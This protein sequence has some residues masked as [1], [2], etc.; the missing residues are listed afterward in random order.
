MKETPLA[1]L[2]WRTMTQPL[3]WHI[4]HIF[5]ANH[6]SESFADIPRD[7]ICKICIF[8]SHEHD[9]RINYV[10]P[11]KTFLYCSAFM[12]EWIVNFVMLYFSQ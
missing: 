3:K 7:N 2:S 4:D 8:S 11:S 6:A 1:W 5:S 10:G 9:L 12:Q